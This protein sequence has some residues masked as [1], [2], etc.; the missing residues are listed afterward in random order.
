MRHIRRTIALLLLIIVFNISPTQ[1]YW[2]TFVLPD[3]QTV[4]ITIQIGEW[5]FEGVDSFDPEI[6]YAP[7]D[8]FKYED[9]KWEVTENWFNPKEFLNSDGTINTSN[10]RPYGPINEKTDEYREYNTY[11]A[12]DI[13]WYEYEGVRY[14]WEA[15]DG[16]ANGVKPG[17]GRAWKLL[18]EVWFKEITYTS[19][20]FVVYEGIRYRAK[21]DT[22]GD[23]PVS[24]SKDYYGPWE[25]L[26]PAR[27]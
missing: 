17:D 3:S 4:E 20:Q 15:R 23:V 26:G 22:Q 12:G 25:L 1:A 16:G 6:M 9:S 8:V 24:D 21:W 13:V 10:L 14:Q 18:S 7:G 5:D 11:K 19:G 27:E 2:A